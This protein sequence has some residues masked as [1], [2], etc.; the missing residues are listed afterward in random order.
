MN[1]K[2]HNKPEPKVSY[3]Q[4]KYKRKLKISKYHKPGIHPEKPKVL[5]TNEYFQ[6]RQNSSR[7]R[8]NS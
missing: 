5:T 8:I 6:K 7:K 1:E 4:A 2:N 3:P